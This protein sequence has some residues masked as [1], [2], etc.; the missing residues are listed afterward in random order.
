MKNSRHNHAVVPNF[1]LRIAVLLTFFTIALQFVVV[2]RYEPVASAIGV[3]DQQSR[4]LNTTYLDYEEQN[5]I[6][7]SSKFLVSEKASGFVSTPSKVL[8]VNPGNTL[9]SSNE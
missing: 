9:V 6:L 8:Y 2:T 3:M 5:A 7:R 4:I 1:V